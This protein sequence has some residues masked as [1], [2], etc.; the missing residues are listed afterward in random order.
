MLL[1]ADVNVHVAGLLEC[2]FVLAVPRGFSMHLRELPSSGI[3]HRSKFISS[4]F[5]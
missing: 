1:W 2:S 4:C 5:R 3:P